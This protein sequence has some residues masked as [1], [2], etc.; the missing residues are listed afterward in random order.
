MVNVDERLKVWELK[1]IWDKKLQQI[2]DDNESGNKKQ[3]IIIV[4]SV[5]KIK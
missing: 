4:G 1:R 3:E 5:W 2:S